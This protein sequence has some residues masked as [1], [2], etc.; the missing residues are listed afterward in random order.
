MST[1]RQGISAA[2]HPDLAACA[3]A[4][5]YGA[6]SRQE[7]DG[8]LREPAIWKCAIEVKTLRMLGDK[9]K[10]NDNMHISLLS[11]C[12][13][14]RSALSDCQKLANVSISRRRGVQGYAFDYPESPMERTLDALEVIVQRAVRV[15]ERYRADF[16]SL[17][18]PVHQ[19]GAVFG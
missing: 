3:P 17:V 11:P 7:C 14:H 8:C 4:V 13:A 10:P 1:Y 16:G 6:G 19:R 9:G 5:P 18:H 2:R 12:P 15:G